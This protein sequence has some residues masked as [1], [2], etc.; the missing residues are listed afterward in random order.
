MALQE[1]LQNLG[2][3]QS[4][5]AN[6]QRMQQVEQQQTATKEASDLLRTFYKSQQE[7]KPDYN[8][9]NEAILRSPELSQNVLNGIGLQDKR[10][11]QQA[12]TD[13][14]TLYQSVGDPQSFGRAM[15]TRINGILERGGDPKDSIELTK[16]YNEQGPEAARRAL[17]QVGAAFINQGYIKQ[18]EMLGFGVAADNNTP[19]SQKELEYYEKLLEKN[20]KLAEQFARKVGLIESGK[21]QSL[22]EAQKDWNT[23]QALK[24]SDPKAANEFGQKAGF[25]SKEGR[26]L[27]A[28]LQKRL[29]EFNDNAA[30]ASSNIVKYNDLASQIESADISG[31]LFGGSWGE[32]YKDITGQQDWKSQLRKDYAQVRSSEAVRNLPAGAASDADIAMALKPFPS[33]NASGA[34]IASFL[35]G[36]AKLS[37]YNAHYNSFKASY[38]SENGSERGMLDAWKKEVGE[39]GI[40]PETPVRD[41]G[42]PKEPEAVTQPPTSEDEALIYSQYGLK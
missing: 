40:K 15:A 16:I 38:I 36:L 22:S 42:K 23:Y 8:S 21:E 30:L 41:L 39:K 6:A 9:L 29:S 35:R 20:P 31:G 12:A 34:E 24:K 28:H 7:G 11:Q 5:A 32:T 33:D 25:V 10:A 26:E 27:S 3:F 37:E 17:Q 19:T 18:P 2:G 14:V 1:M 4:L 13:V